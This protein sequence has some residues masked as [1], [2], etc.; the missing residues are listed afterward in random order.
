MIIKNINSDNAT[1][2][3]IA[4][5]GN[6]DGLHLG[7]QAIIRQIVELAQQ[8]N[9]L[10]TVI[11]FEPQPQEFFY[12][13]KSPA[14]L[15]NLQEKLFY[16]EQLKVEQVMVLD[17][18]EKLK[19]LS[20]DDFIQ[21][22]LI[23]KLK[24]KHLIVGDDFKFGAD[25]QG[26]VTLLKS[27]KIFTVENTPTIKINEQRVSSSRVREALATANFEL[28]KQLLGRAY[29]LR[30]EVINGDKN[31]RKIA[32]P[33]ANI[34]PNRLVL[35][36]S[37]VFAVRAHGLDKSYHG[38]ANL[39][40]RPTVDGLRTLLETHIFDFE[41]TIYGETLDIEF[42]KKIRDEKKFAN[43]SEL[44]AQIHRDVAEVKQFF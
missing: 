10:S 24:L 17:F 19:N 5:I 42:I 32:V 15:T 29:S 3:C 28:A 26:D 27:N 22:Q 40:T 9:C 1:Q 8:Q 30:G 16:L 44:E 33:T 38:I 20:A 14:R 34:D 35:P 6:F 7:H 21:T 11:I 37:G 18:D 25:R 13:I 39:G 2:A 41:Q 31:G 36:F 43:F 12:G 4:T 23:D